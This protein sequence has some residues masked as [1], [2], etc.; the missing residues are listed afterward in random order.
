M[1]AATIYE[2]AG[3]IF[4][5][6]SS[7]TS[8]GIWVISP[9]WFAVDQINPD[10]VGRLI[11][12]CL[13]ESREGVSHPES[14]DS[15]FNPI[16]EMAGIKSWNTFSK[17]A[18]CVGVETIDDQ[19]VLFESTLNEGVGGGYSPLSFKYKASMH[20]ERDLGHKALEALKE[21]K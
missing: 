14:S 15:I 13:I 17:L 18:R 7:K 3:R 11:K 2:C 4:M 21:S 5:H 12:Q 16:L 6:S 1:K 10:D 19:V 20:S 8:A 9:P